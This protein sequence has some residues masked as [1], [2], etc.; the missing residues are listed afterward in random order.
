MTVNDIYELRRQGRTEEA[1]DA[2]RRLYAGDKSPRASAAMFW[3]AVDVLKA[4]V[5]E[6]SLDEAH[7]ILSALERM[8]PGVPDAKGWVS[9][10]FRSCQQLLERADM[11]SKARAEHHLVGVWGEELA[12][13]YLREKGYV[14]L[15][16][17]WHSSHR[18][19]DIIARH[20]GSLVFIEVKTRRSADYGDPSLAV[21][22]R[23]QRNLR[24]AI[25][26]YIKYKKT[27]LPCRFDILSIVGVPGCAN[28][29]IRHQEDV[30]I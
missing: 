29:E 25:N 21:D 22:Y 10:A 28:P 3:T 26:H 20:A 4:R 15:E 5:G 8:L 2:A 11:N 9:N 30:P 1:Y 18:D 23:K 13:A 17:D 16:R 12:V 14:I 27:D 6:S 24:L 19:I 7:M